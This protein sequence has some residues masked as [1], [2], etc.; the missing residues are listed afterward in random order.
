MEHAVVVHLCLQNAAT[1]QNRPKLPSRA[2]KL[3]LALMAKAYSAAGQATSA[4][5]A[6]AI[7]R[8]IRPKHEGSSEP[9]LIQEL[10]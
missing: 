7:L 6:M 9:G 1:W 5:H 3:T 10:H 4:L 8:S 2:C